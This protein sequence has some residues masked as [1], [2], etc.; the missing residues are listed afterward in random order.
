[1]SKSGL[2]VGALL[3]LTG[4]VPPEQTAVVG[5]SGQVMSLARCSQSPNGCY[6]QASETCQGSYQV[7]DSYSKSGG[8]IADVLPGP[9]TWYYMNYQCGASD[10]RTPSFPFRGQQ[11]VPPP[12][13][14]NPA[15]VT[16]TTNCNRFG[17]NVTCTT[18]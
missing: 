1:M 6:Q 9:V 8:L 5:P 14:V 10:G 13:V 3:V 7:L 17:N 16:T 2:V 18:R 11:Y 4:C 15:P 12:I